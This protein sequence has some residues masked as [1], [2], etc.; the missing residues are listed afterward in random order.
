MKLV[1]EHP[2]GAWEETLPIGNGR[3]G[4]M[5]FGGISEEVIGLN[6]DRLWNGRADFDKTPT[7]VSEYLPKVRELAEN[8]Q[9]AEADHVAE[10]HLF[11]YPA[12]NYF[13]IGS[14]HFQMMHH[15]DAEVKRYQRIL[16][17]DNALVRVSY[18]IDGK[19][20]ERRFF[21]SYPAKA[22]IMKFNG[23][24][25]FSMKLSFDSVID[26]AGIFQADAEK[27]ELMNVY[28][29][30]RA[31][32]DHTT[33]ERIR[34]SGK[35]DLISWKGEHSFSE[36][37]SADESGLLMKDVTEV[38]FAFSTDAAE[39]QITDQDTYDTLFEKHYLDY[40]SLFD[41][42]ELYLGEDSDLPTDERIKGIAE[43]NPDP[44]LFAL[45]FQYARYLMISASREGSN[46]MNLQGIWSWQKWAPWG[47]NYTVN[48][49]A[50]MNY[51]PALSTNLVDCLGP[52]FELVR[53]MTES[54]K[55]TAA[56]Y[57]CRGAASGHNSDVWGTTCP[58][59]VGTEGE[60]AFLS[61][62]WSMW[63]MGISWMCQQLWY[64]YEYTDDTEFLK[65]SIYPIFREQ[66]LF[67]N[68][69]LYEKDG[70]YIT[71]PSTSPENTFKMEDGKEAAIAISSTMDLTLIRE[72]FGNFRK[73]CEILGI[74][75]E[76]L[77][78]IAEKEAKLYPFRIGKYGQLQE[79]FRDFEEW[80]PGHR[81]VSHL[82]GAFPGELFENDP[83]LMKAAR[84]SLERRLA[85]GGGHTGWS[86]AW[87]INLFA[88][89][90]DGEKA[91]E[92]LR[93]L[94][95]RSTYPNMWDKHPP[96]Q[97]DGN[98]GGAA[99]IANMLVTERAGKLKILP[100]LPKAWKNGFV[101]GL[102]IR[103][104]RIIDISWE[105]GKLKEYR[106][107]N[108]A[109]SYETDKEDES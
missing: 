24:E 52:Y 30:C 22:I 25:A 39:P 31:A 44:S 81:H 73:T 15:S 12:D 101:R 95:G 72:M 45:Y 106:I 98:F 62:R 46:A 78:E 100:A 57:G 61:A 83:E 86:C 41:R 34:F 42:V 99:G 88:I 19:R 14:L 77:P 51:W 67:L 28:G 60:S 32:D 27:K 79:W 64:Y 9:Y 58:I 75:D 82:Y 90:G 84:V 13:P 76:L 74:E 66:V 43:G 49:N 65:E 85:N 68:D 87:I 104:G 17:L 70:Y 5:I 92:Y 50:E 59:G 4:A 63:L 33:E 11:G 69:W 16:R 10:Q 20:Y 97:I 94:L 109:E 108:D 56:A 29:V 96:F 36:T 48:I 102:R 6:D 8:G 53:K 23:E 54:G 55:R 80:E 47:A 103:H 105:N 1:Y 7:E 38:V 40:S 37:F 35:L 91:Y 89:F 93:V 18:K 3:L 26:A 2:A 71:C 107:R 21:A